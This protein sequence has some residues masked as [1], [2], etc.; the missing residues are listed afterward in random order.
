MNISVSVLISLEEWLWAGNLVTRKMQTKWIY[1][2]RAVEWG[3]SYSPGVGKVQTCVYVL[4]VCV[5]VGGGY[6]G[7]QP[8][9]SSERPPSN[10]GW[11]LCPSAKSPYSLQVSCL[12]YLPDCSISYPRLW[13][14]VFKNSLGLVLIIVYMPVNSWA[15]LVLKQIIWNSY[16]MLMSGTLFFIITSY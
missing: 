2:T 7:L 10:K 11:A 12:M 5:Y 1:V 6:K 14:V 4:N 16:K 3:R 15:S 8:T 9:W 13:T